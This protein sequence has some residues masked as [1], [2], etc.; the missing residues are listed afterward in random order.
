[1][2]KIECLYVVHLRIAFM[3]IL[4]FFS[5]FEILGYSEISFPRILCYSAHQFSLRRMISNATNGWILSDPWSNST[6][7][8]DE[9]VTSWYHFLKWGSG[10]SLERR[11][12]LRNLHKLRE[13]FARG[14]FGPIDKCFEGQKFF[15]LQNYLHKFG[16]TIRMAKFYVE[17]LLIFENN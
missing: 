8:Q 7:C 16:S 4:L 13:R 10:R 14:W 17:C 12:F 2:I 3:I 9:F 1:M 6:D 5:S 15:N 11:T